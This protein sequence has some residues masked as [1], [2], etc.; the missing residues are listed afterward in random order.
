M[1]DQPLDL[2]LLASSLQADTGD[3]GL[4]LRVL[5]ARLGGALGNRLRVERGGGLLRRNDQIRRVSIELGDDLLEAA[6]EGGSVRCTVGRSSGGIRIRS[7]KVT[8]DEWLHQL[9][10]ALREEASSS[11]ATRQALEAMMLGGNK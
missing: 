1:G 7:T 8:M 4:L 2:D 11:Q 3:V 5:V 6:V 10:E 9:L